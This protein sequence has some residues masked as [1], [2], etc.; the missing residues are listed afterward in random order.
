MTEKRVL[1]SACLLGM[2]CR[3]D[4]RAKPCNAVLRLAAA[5]AELVPVCPE[6]LGGLPTPR[7]SAEIQPDGRVLT[8]DG[9]D[10]T[11]NYAS[12]AESALRLARLLGC[13]AAILKARSPSCG[14]GTVYDGS[15]TGTLVNGWGFTAQRLR[16]AGIGVMTEEDLTP[17]EDAPRGTEEF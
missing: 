16:G 10:V 5:G 6:Q 11:E 2:P 3:Y 13:R 15:F 17:G 9:R 4:G 14:C 7:T 8:A 1:V 12:G